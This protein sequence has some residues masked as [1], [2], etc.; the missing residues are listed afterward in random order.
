M[1]TKEMREKAGGLL[2][3]AQESLDKG[4]VGQFEKV[5][6]DA[7]IMMK[8][9]DE[10]E[11]AQLKLKALSGDFNKPLNTVPV[12]SKDVEKYNTDDTTRNTKADY[13][14]QTWIKG[15]PA[16]SQPIWVQEQCGDNVKDHARFQKDTFMKWMKA[17]SEVAFQM[18]A[19]PDEQKAMQED[20]DTEGLIKEICLVS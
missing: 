18:T 7:Q 8:Q 13:K 10:I 9:A 14:P 1:N 3:T 12:A 19:T 6:L 5:I 17:P 16:M 2:K 15:L 4:E 20:T 11:E